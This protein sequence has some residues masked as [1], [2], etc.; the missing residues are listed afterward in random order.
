MEQLKNE[1]EAYNEALNLVCETAHISQKTFNET[2]AAEII[3]KQS[4]L[5]EL[6]N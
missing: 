2:Y 3:D 6:L 5:N 1:F 4:I